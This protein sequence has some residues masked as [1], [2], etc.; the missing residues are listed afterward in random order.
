[1]FVLTCIPLIDPEGLGQNNKT[2]KR[3]KK[4]KDLE[5]RDRYILLFSGNIIIY[6]EILA[7]LTRSLNIMHVNKLPIRSACKNQ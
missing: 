6:I 3:I 7:V 5:K 4:L 1:M 2:W